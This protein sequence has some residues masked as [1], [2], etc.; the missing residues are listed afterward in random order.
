M[1]T[2]LLCPF[3]A[4]RHWKLGIHYFVEYIYTSLIKRASPVLICLFFQMNKFDIIKKN[5]KML[6]IQ[7]NSEFLAKDEKKAQ[8][9]PNI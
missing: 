9:S 6:K 5:H 7:E 1:D 8:L 2:L 3:G 4:D